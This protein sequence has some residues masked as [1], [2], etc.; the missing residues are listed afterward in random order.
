MTATE[1]SETTRR[2]GLELAE[3]E[4]LVDQLADLLDLVACLVDEVEHVLAGER[5][6]LEE[7]EEPGERRAQLVGDRRR[8]AGPQLLV[9]GQIAATAQVDQA[10]AAAPHVVGDDERDDP[11]LAREQALRD[12]LALLQPLDRLARAAAAGDHAILGVEDDHRLAA[13]LE[14]HPASRRVGVHPHIV[15]TDE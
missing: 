6:G 3:E 2:A 14:E 7:R 12:L 15:L 1:P 5:R 8:E 10:L 9:R 4:H 11:R 13:L